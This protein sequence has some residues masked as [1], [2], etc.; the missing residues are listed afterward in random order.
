MSTI[1][2]HTPIYLDYA[3]TTP[4]DPQVADKMC[5]C[6]TSTGNFGNP[7]SHSHP[8]GWRASRAVTQAREQVAALIN[9]DV[10]EIIWTSGATESNNLALQGIAHFY[11]DQR[12]HIITIRSEHH[13]VLDPCRYLEKKGFSVTYL[14]P[15]SDG[16]VDMVALA[17]ALRPD[18]VLVSVMYVNNETGVM[19]DI[20]SIAA[21]VKANGSFFHVDAAQAAGKIPIDMQVVPVDLLSISAHKFY[22]PKGVGVLFVR[23]KPTVKLE[24]MIH[25]GGQEQ[26]LRSGTL[27]THQVVGMGEACALALQ[28]MVEDAQHIRRLRDRFVDG[29]KGLEGVGVNGSLEHHVGGILNIYFRGI[30]NDLLMK[31]LPQLAI[32]SGSACTSATMEPSYVLKAMGIEDAIAQSSL[33]FSFGRLT[34]EEDIDYAIHLISAKLGALRSMVTCDRDAPAK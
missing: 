9:A 18:T 8:Y 1:H 4:V 11:Q 24:A 30:D 32:S 14:S 19:Q 34:M 6:L 33:R 26:G 21:L 29:L 3:A 12:R 22:G 31:A 17:Q 28:R 20:A 13:A 5:Q 25:G 2:M 27:A 15:R 10:R 16:L 7:A 23:R